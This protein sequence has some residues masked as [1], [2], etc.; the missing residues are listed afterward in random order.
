MDAVVVET[1]T[2]GGALTGNAA[3]LDRL[4]QNENPLMTYSQMMRLRLSGAAAHECTD[5][6]FIA[7]IGEEAVS[8]IWYGWGKHPDAAGNFGNFRTEEKWR[9]R[10]IGGQVLSALFRDRMERRDLPLALFC[11]AGT[12]EIIKLYARYGFRLAVR[13]RETG[14]LYCPLGGSPASFQEF[15]AKYYAPSGKLTVRP[16]FIGWRHEI[17]CLL[18]FCLTDLGI[19]FGLPGVANLED[20]LL[21]PGKGQAELFFAENGHCVGWAFTPAGGVRAVQLHPFF[22]L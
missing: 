7:A 2:P 1:F 22:S 3:K 20:A 18:N 19:P 16:A 5:R 12:R 14:P 17:D 15:C 9:G 8:R 4:L 13:N 11:T 21:N 10:G 6:F